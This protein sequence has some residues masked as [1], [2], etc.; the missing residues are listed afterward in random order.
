ML[1][2]RCFGLRRG[3]GRT[4][5]G[6]AIYAFVQYKTKDYFMDHLSGTSENRVSCARTR[7]TGYTE[8]SHDRTGGTMNDA[9]DGGHVGHQSCLGTKDFHVHA[10][11]T[12]GWHYDQSS[13]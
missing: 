8:C 3:F 2:D 13:F 7:M 10:H 4:L 9:H 1:G 5:N 6:D 11:N 12:R